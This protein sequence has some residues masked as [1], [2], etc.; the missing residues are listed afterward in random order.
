MLSIV[1]P[2]LC[3]AVITVSVTG[4]TIS[5]SFKSSYVTDWSISWIKF[6]TW[7]S[8]VNIHPIIISQSFKSTLMNSINSNTLNDSLISTSPS[9]SSVKAVKSVRSSSKNKKPTLQEKTGFVF[10]KHDDGTDIPIIN[11][12]MWFRIIVR[13]KSEKRI[14]DSVMKLIKENTQWAKYFNEAAFPIDYYVR[15]KGKGLIYTTKPLTPGVVYLKMKMNKQLYDLVNGV[16]GV[17]GFL[18]SNN[19]MN[20]VLPVSPEDSISMDDM[21][22]KPILEL[23]PQHARMRKEEYVSVISGEHEGRYG[24]FMGTKLGKIEVCLRSE[25]KDDW[26]CFD[27]NELEYLEHP[28]EKK[29]KV[30]SQFI[31]LRDLHTFTKNQPT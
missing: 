30:S 8:N 10:S 19:K 31:L 6:K 28:P 23:K 7:S 29:W 4:L 18:K 24:I 13:K 27:L 9:N 15:M 11:D 21:K 12:Y 5:R 22:N 2:I 26:A 3:L 17:Y 14:C 16:N 20:V 25:F 1:I